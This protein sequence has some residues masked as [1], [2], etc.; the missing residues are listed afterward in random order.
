MIPT[1]EVPTVSLIAGL[2]DE[3]KS[4]DDAIAE[5]IGGYNGFIA[6]IAEEQ[7]GKRAYISTFFFDHVGIGPIVRV[8]QHAVDSREYKPL[9]TSDYVPRGNTPLYDAI[10]DAIALLDK[11]AL[12]K[13]VNRVTFVVQTD[14]KEN[15]SRRFNLAAVK[16]LIEQRQAAGWQIIFLGAD[17]K[18]APEIGV[19]LGILRSNSM[20][21]AKGQSI[22]TFDAMA[23]GT[24]SYRSSNSASASITLTDEQKAALNKATS[25]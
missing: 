5:T 18:D 7:Q 19:N 21:Y 9:K 13:G 15:A 23:V 22:E 2:I 16:L 8:I 24:Q 20:T 17:L 14:G 1:D 25:A 6:K 12:E 11:T 3:S 10:G 4:M